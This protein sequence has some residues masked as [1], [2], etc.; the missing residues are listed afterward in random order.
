M[1]NLAATIRAEIARRGL[2]ANQL[3]RS[4]GVAQTRISAFLRGGDMQGDNLSKL[5]LALGLELK[6]TK[7]G[8]PRG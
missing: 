8:R 3:A 5:C 4:T 6:P 1:T 7:P 2:S